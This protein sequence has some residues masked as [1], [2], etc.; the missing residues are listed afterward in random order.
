MEI[1]DGEKQ[2]S[3]TRLLDKYEKLSRAD[4]QKLLHTIDESIDMLPIEQFM[5]A[6]SIEDLQN[7]FIALVGSESFSEFKTLIES[8]RTLG[9]AEEIEFSGGLI[10]GFDYYDGMIFEMFDTNPE[11]PRAL[12]GGGRYNGLADIFGVKGGIS[13]VGFAPG[14]ETMKLFL[15][16]HDLL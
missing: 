9:Y 16:G 13:A 12:F 14:D 10:R 4:F 2:K 5:S 6:R 3:I 7:S 8:L 15:E 1:T 11:N